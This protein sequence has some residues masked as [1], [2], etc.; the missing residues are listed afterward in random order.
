LSKPYLTKTKE[1]NKPSQKM[2]KA[3]KKAKN[4]VLRTMPCFGEGWR[5][6]KTKESNKPKQK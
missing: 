1:S 4:N 5:W 2:P 3:S 6:S